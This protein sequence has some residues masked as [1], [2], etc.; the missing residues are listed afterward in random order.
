[1]SEPNNA[2]GLNR[3]EL[4]RMCD[5][6]ARADGGDENAMPA[7]REAFAKLPWFADAIGGDLARKAVENLLSVIAPKGLAQQEAIHRKMEEIRAELL[8]HQSAPLERLLVERVV[9]CWLHAY[10]ADTQYARS[11]VSFN[12]G[13]YLQKQQDR[14]QRR[15]LSAIKTLAVVR[16]LA[17]P[18]KVDVKVA[19]T[20]TAEPAKE[21]GGLPSRLAGAMSAN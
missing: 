3:A 12:E 15:Y 5:A 10:H 9:V 19:A 20:V 14:A 18:I 7:V 8:G 4:E 13:E 6:V 21:A 17:L 1:M 16:R 2:D 11:S